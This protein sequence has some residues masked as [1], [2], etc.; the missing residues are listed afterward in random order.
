M[1]SWAAQLD[2][3]RREPEMGGE[4]AAVRQ[5]IFGAILDFV[6]AH[7]WDLSNYL[8]TSEDENDLAEMVNAWL[9]REEAVPA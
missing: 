9:D 8:T 7:P 2:E 6:E 4:E 1:T 5:L 3:W